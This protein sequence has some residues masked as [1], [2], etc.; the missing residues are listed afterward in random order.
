MGYLSSEKGI[1]G[2]K[3]I[4]SLCSLLL[5]LVGIPALAASFPSGVCPALNLG[6]NPV[7]CNVQ[8]TANPNGTLSIAIVD[9][10]PYELFDDMEV[11]FFNN[12]TSIVN[13][14]TLSGTATANGGIFGYDDDDSNYDPSYISTTNIK[15]DTFG[16]A[17]SGTVNFAGGV[18]PGGT[19]WFA[20]EES[21]AGG[22]IVGNVG[23]AVPEPSPVLLML[24]GLLGL[25][26]LAYRKQFA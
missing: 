2:M 20:L 19:A 3:T 21:P 26:G 13:A 8:I 23:P 10:A 22:S 12:S 9:S 4:A 18:A 11:G 24:T 7:D 14:I 17:I 16:N 15:D 6:H 25:L 1:H 5:L